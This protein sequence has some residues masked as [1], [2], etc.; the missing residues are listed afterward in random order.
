M[1]TSASTTRQRSS[2][3][4]TSGA[5]FEAVASRS[6]AGPTTPPEPMTTGA[7]LG[8]GGVAARG[9]A[10]GFKARGAVVD[11]LV[12]WDGA[13]TAVADTKPLLM[14]TCGGVGARGAGAEL[15]WVAATGPLPPAV[16]C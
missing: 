8:D 4:T 11:R 9:A 5:Q 15:T 16:L 7:V 1:S 13:V 14:L 3:T 6:G 2:S 12:G 10:P